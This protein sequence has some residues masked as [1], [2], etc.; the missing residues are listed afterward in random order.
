[1]FLTSAP[2]LGYTNSSAEAA[3]LVRHCLASR[4]KLARVVDVKNMAD[5][6]GKPYSQT[7]NKMRQR[8][9]KE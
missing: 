7:Q 1:M 4:A 9:F 5:L 2:G 6:Q 8:G 3:Q